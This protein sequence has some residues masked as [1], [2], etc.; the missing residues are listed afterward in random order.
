VAESA[1]PLWAGPSRFSA[2]GIS[3]RVETAR[4]APKPPSGYRANSRSGY[5]YRIAAPDDQDRIAI[6]CAFEAL[7][8]AEYQQT[9]EDLKPDRHTSAGD[10]DAGTL[11]NTGKCLYR[12]QPGT[13]RTSSL[14][15]E[16]LFIPLFRPYLRRR[17]PAVEPLPGG[18]FGWF[19]SATALTCIKGRA[20]PGHSQR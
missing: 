8:I 20:P 6:H 17:S 10:R 12:T 9:Y 3:G 5:P 14:E 18:A 4:S 15:W 13:H 7:R 19:D 11:A 1:L 2:V 16:P